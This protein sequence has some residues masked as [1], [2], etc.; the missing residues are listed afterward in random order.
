MSPSVPPRDDRWILRARDLLQQDAARPDAALQRRLAAIRSQALG[1]PAPRAALPWWG[2]GGA[3]AALLVLGVGVWQQLLPV[4]PASST[5]VAPEAPALRAESPLEQSLTLPSDD[6]ALLA[7]ED[8]YALL[9]ELEFYAW[10]EGA[11]HGG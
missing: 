6:L 7:G 3:V 2:V 4:D 8:D 11:G 9:E 5:G 10:L 1:N